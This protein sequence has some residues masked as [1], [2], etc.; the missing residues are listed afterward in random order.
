MA[1]FN[2]HGMPYSQVMPEQLAE[3]IRGGRGDGIPAA[4]DP[5]RFL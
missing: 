1:A 5:A 3:R 4:F 2:G